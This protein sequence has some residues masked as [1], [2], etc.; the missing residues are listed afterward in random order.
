MTPDSPTIALGQTEP[1]TATGTYTDGTTADLT[2]RWPGRRSAPSIA[3][4]S[5]AGVATGVGVGTA[6]IT[7]SLDGVASPADTL[8]VTAAPTTTAAANASTPFSEAQ[9]VR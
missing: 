2:P 8:T 7:A 4:I 6:G 1:F 3:S 5:G 9:A